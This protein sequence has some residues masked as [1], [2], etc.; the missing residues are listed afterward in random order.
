MTEQRAQRGEELMMS[1]ERT[2][3]FFASLDGASPPEGLKPPV[4]AVWHGLRGE[5]AEAHAIVQA[6]EDAD[7]A[8]VHAWL[9]RVEGD[10]GNARY[11]Y[12]R[13]GRSVAQGA[14][15]HEGRTIAA[16]LLRGGTPRP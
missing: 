14:T 13:A 9:H 7:A 16:A 10:L 5:W 4:R 1:N 8:W 3:R 12:R 2:E 15:D 11:W 6:L